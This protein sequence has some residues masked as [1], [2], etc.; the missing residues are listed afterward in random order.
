LTSLSGWGILKAEIEG[1]PPSS[2]FN[3]LIATLPQ[4]SPKMASLFL[5]FFTP[6]PLSEVSGE[7]SAGTLGRLDT[8]GK[9]L[10]LLSLNEPSFILGLNSKLLIRAISRE[11]SFSQCRERPSRL[12]MFDSLS[13]TLGGRYG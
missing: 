13:S 6:F 8:R 4:R 12:D 1:H 2:W 3:Y 7:K 10:Y 11:Y 5:T 9:D